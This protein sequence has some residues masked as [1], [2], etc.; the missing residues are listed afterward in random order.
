MLAGTIPRALYFLAIPGD[1]TRARDI[2]TTN[3]AAGPDPILSGPVV[4]PAASVTVPSH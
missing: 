2:R 4:L 3:G 1:E